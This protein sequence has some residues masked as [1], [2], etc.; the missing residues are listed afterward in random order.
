[1]EAGNRAH[2]ESHKVACR[3]LCLC[4]G[5]GEGGGDRAPTES[6]KVAL[7]HAGPALFD[8]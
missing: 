1:M 8:D 6:H 5:G 3:C 7:S 4:G 2:T